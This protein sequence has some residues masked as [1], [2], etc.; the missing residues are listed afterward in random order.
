[1]LLFIE[2]EAA[3]IRFI[4]GNRNSKEK[5]ADQISKFLGISNIRLIKETVTSLL[6]LP[7]KKVL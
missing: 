4:G 2:V 3:S 7:K 5:L 6:S 1:M